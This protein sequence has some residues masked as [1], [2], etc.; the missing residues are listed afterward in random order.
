[1]WEQIGRI[2]ACI[3]FIN[4]IYNHLK[5]LLVIYIHECVCVCVCVRARARA[6]MCVCAHVCA[7]TCVHVS[8]PEMVMSP[9]LLTRSDLLILGP[10]P[11]RL[12]PTRS[13]QTR[14][15]M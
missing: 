13:A 10:D 3:I 6:R 1:M 15:A 11:T 8:V 7:Y 14:S 12:Y 5:S 2:S 9:I 4:I